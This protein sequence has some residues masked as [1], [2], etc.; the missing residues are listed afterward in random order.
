VL[1]LLL[2]R[3]GSPRF[4][5]TGEHGVIEDAREVAEDAD[6]AMGEGEV[7]SLQTFWWG[8]GGRRRE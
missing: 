3:D 4:A 5:N 2:L 6:E 7:L 1:L 8:F